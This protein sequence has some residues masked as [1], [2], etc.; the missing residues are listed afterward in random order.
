MTNLS[1]PVTTKREINRVEKRNMA[2]T[3]KLKLGPGRG[4]AA[5]ARDDSTVSTAESS[6]ASPVHDSVEYSFREKLK[7]ADKVKNCHTVNI[8]IK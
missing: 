7:K 2:K 6:R 8:C 4:A 1:T 3:S 5:I